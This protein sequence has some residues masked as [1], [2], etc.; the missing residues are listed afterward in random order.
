MKKVFASIALSTVLVFSSIPSAFANEV[1]KQVEIPSDVLVEL[2]LSMDELGISKETQSALISKLES[3]QMVDSENPAMKDKGVTEKIDISDNETMLRTTYPDGSVSQTKIDNTK[4]EV[5]EEQ[6]ITPQ[7]T[8]DGGTTT[9][10]TGYTVYTG[11]RVYENNVFIKCEYTADFVKVGSGYGYSYINN[12]YDSFIKVAG[13]TFNRVSFGVDNPQETSGP[14]GRPA[15]ASLVFDA[16]KL[17]FF[18]S[19]YAL[20]LYVSTIANVIQVQYESL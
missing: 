19:T 3:G 20:Y 10:G 12:V 4:A 9:P 11:V 1:V 8:Y 7:A 13:G 6:V 14:N 18:Q 15:R 5:T 17:G 2:H 16:T